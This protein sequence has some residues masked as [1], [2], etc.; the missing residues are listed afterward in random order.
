MFYFLTPTNKITS[1][2]HFICFSHKKSFKGHKVD[3]VILDLTYSRKFTN[4]KV[5]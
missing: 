2:F 1:G 5:Y 3:I 4:Q